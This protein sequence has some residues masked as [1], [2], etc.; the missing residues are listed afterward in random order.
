MKKNKDI[1]R[2]LTFLIDS[3]CEGDNAYWIDIIHDGIQVGY[4]GHGG[5]NI[6]NTI[7]YKLIKLDD[8][9][10]IVKER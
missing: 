3:T 8:A 7:N 2:A 10:R 6:T 1:T 5:I 4:I 9:F